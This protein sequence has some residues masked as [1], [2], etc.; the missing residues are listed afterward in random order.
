MVQCTIYAQISVLWGNDNI[1]F[2]SP[3]WGDNS[4]GLRRKYGRGTMDGVS[5]PALVDVN[6]AVY[7]L[8]TDI[9]T[10]GKG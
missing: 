3:Q 9:Y 7:H 1:I 8:R 2:M 4:K 6:G 5:V 10:L